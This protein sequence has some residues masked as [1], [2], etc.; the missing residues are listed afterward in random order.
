MARN[1]CPICGKKCFGDFCV[2]HK[3]MN[4][5]PIRRKNKEYVVKSSH[6]MLEFFH[7]I[8]KERPHKS[9]ISGEN[10]FEFSSALFHHILLKEKYKEA[11]FDKEN[12]ILLSLAEHEHVHTNMHFNEEINKRREELKIK[13]NI[14]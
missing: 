2:K 3:P 10:L 7:E 12:I 6:D 14:L 5:I 13:Y 9:E 8:W 4:P 1:N 11:A